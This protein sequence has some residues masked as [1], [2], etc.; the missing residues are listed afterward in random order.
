MRKKKYDWTFSITE[1]RWDV[2][3]SKFQSTIQAYIGPFNMNLSYDPKLND[4]KSIELFSKKMN[5]EIE[6]T[7]TKL[8]RFALKQVRSK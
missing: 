7:K 3:T 2:L 6:K 4:E 5:L 8:K 1:P